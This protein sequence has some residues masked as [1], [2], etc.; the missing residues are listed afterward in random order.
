MDSD[1]VVQVVRDLSDIELATLV[2][3]VAEQHCI[4]RTADDVL[5]D[6]A[7]EIAI[8]SQKIFGLSCMV[9]DL[10]FGSTLSVFDQA[11]FDVDGDGADTTVRL[12]EYSSWIHS[13]SARLHQRHLPNGLQTSRTNLRRTCRAPQQVSRREWPMWL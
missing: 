6:V 7:D 3:L 2:C 11:V 10:N 9:L 4:I 5:D 12:V 13:H 1:S 8:A